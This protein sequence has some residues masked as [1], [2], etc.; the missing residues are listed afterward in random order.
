MCKGNHETVY[1]QSTA[2][3]VLGEKAE[4]LAPS[5]GPFASELLICSHEP[6]SLH[7]RRRR[8][9]ILEAR[10]LAGPSQTAARGP[11]GSEYEEVHFKQCL[12]S[13]HSLLHVWL[14]RVLYIGT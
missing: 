6:K 2:Q 11:G 13:S 9:F 3:E 4:A 7:C 10:V 14:L 12:L 8:L 5:V 1:Y